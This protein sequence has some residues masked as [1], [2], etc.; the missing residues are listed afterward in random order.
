MTSTTQT[1]TRI[2]ADRPRMVPTPRVWGLGSL[3]R[4]DL[5]RTV[6]L[7]SWTTMVHRAERLERAGYLERRG[8]IVDGEATFVPTISGRR[9]CLPQIT[10]RD[11]REGDVPDYTTDP[12]TM[13][14][15]YGTYV[16]VNAGTDLRYFDATWPLFL[17][18]VADHGANHRF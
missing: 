13:V 9:A 2:P 8:P 7:G 5:E 14:T 4:L 15:D 12:V 18:T 16:A 11:L 3:D 1:P 6:R 17:T 10:A